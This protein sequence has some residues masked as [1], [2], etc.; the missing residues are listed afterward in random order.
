MKKIIVGIF[1]HPDDEAFGPSATLLKERLGGAE[2]HLICVTDG[3]AGANP[4]NYPDLAAVRCDEWREAG[5]LIGATSMTNLGFADGKLCN[6]DFIKLAERLEKEI[7]CIV[8]QQPAQE[9]E[10]ELMTLDLNGLTGHLD[11]IFVARVACYLHC[12]LKKQ[13]PSTG[14][15]RLFCVAHDDF[16]E[17]NCDWVY[18]EP[19]RDHEHINET[20]DARNLYDRVDEIMRTHKSQANDYNS[21]HEKYGERIAINHFVVI[22]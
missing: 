18:M 16:P 8:N 4:D 15:L 19:G 13:L 1:A 22:S 6:A 17:V 9:Y 20:V 7:A 5:R 2:I 12:K 3:E 11:H 10:L 14:K 21:I